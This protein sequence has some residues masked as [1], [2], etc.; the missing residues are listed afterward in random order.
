[1]HTF[2]VAP[3]KIIVAKWIGYLALI[4]LLLFPYFQLIIVPYSL[5]LITLGFFLLDLRIKRDYYIELYI[6]IGGAVFTSL[7]ISIFLPPYSEFIVNN[8][9]YAFQ[10][11]TSFFYFFYFRCLTK[12]TQLNITPIII[13]FIVWFTLLGIMFLNTPLY[14]NELIRSIYGRLVSSEYITIEDFRFSYVFSDPNTGIYFFLTA[15]APL[16]M[17][18]KKNSFRLM[19][20]TVGALMVLISQS[21]GGLSAYC[22]M[23]IVLIFDKK[24]RTFLSFKK[25]LVFL[26]TAIAFSWLYFYFMN[27]MQDNIIVE[28]AFKR[29][30]GEGDRL[31]G[32]GGRFKHWSALYNNLLPLPFGRGY[33]LYEQATDYIRPPHSDFFGLLYRY[34]FVA[35]IPS[36]FFFFGKYQKVA[37]L[38]I[39]AAMAF[40]I[41]SLLDEQKLFALF[42]SLLAVGITVTPQQNKESL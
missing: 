22:L 6:L 33:T 2:D 23:T 5:P 14:T 3:Q 29:L 36:L 10:F 27:L 34:G 28:A 35:L 24:M 7:A 39:P 11:L 25:L 31:E 26:L 30:S 37:P 38:L 15:I 32:G 20:L 40:A 17:S 18:A 42:L 12:R 19:L 8:T 16:L 41:N 1:M 21:T 4:D 13:I 9:K